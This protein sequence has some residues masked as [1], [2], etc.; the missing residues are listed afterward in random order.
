MKTK[1]ITVCPNLG[2]GTAASLKTAEHAV[3]IMKDINI[4]TADQR[5]RVRRP[6][7]ST[8]RA[9]EPAKMKLKIWSRP[10]MRVCVS[11]SVMPIVSRTR[12]R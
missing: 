10:F 2:L 4:P 6:R 5:K 12:V 1:A 8:R 7:R 3:Q 9:A 11:G